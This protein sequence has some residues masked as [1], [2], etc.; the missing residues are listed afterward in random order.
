MAQEGYVQTTATPAPANTAE[1]FSGTSANADT[2]HTPTIGGRVQEWWLKIEVNEVLI[3]F[4][5]NDDSWESLD[6]PLAI[7][8]HCLQRTAKAIRIKSRLTDLHANYWM[9]VNSYV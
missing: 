3:D 1:S 5:R 8:A 2:T 7:G 6:F 9:V 4:Q